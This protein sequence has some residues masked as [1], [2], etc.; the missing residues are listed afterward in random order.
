MRLST[1]AIPFMAKCW[2]ISLTTVSIVALTFTLVAHAESQNI[3]LGGV[4][5]GTGQTWTYVDSYGNTIADA[6]T[7]SASSVYFQDVTGRSYSA[8]D[9]VHKIDEHYS[10][11]YNSTYI[12]MSGG[13][14]LV[15]WV[16]TRH[17]WRLSQYGGDYTLFTSHNGNF[18]TSSC[19]YQ[20]YPCPPYI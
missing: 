14:L 5:T 12:E 18:S 15:S 1:R 9:Y 4:T 8:I 17:Y 16:T 11:A 20:A 3:N 13:N 7:S 2:L 10:S 6:Y 19:Y